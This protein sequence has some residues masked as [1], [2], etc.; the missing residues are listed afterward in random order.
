MKRRLAAIMILTIIV[1][2]FSGC[3]PTE[4]R[5]NE[6]TSGNAFNS[7]Y[8]NDTHFE[9]SKDNLAVGFDFPDVPN[10]LPSKIKLREKTFDH[11]EMIELFFGGEAPVSENIYGAN[12]ECGQ[13][14]AIDGAEL[15]IEGNDISYYSGKISVMNVVE[16]LKAPV[17][18]FSMMNLCK[19][20]NRDLYSIGSDELEDFSLQNALDSVQELISKLGLAGF[21]SP[22]IYSFSLAAYEKIR[23]GEYYM[24]NEEYPL[25]K[26]DEI[27][28]FVYPRLYG[29]VELS[30]FDGVDI[31]DS[32]NEIGT[33]ITS[34]SLTV[35]VAKDGIFKFSVGEAYEAD[36][37]ILSTEPVK[38]NFDYA[39]SVLE[40]YLDN[41]YFS[42]RKTV[43]INNARVLYFPVERN[44]AG[45]V[46]FTPLWSFEGYVRDMQ[47]ES[48]LD[49]VSL[50]DYRLIIN[51]DVG[52]V[53]EYE[54]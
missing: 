29:E 44:E 30:D 36:V 14:I 13:Y 19:E 27:Y 18:Y 6:N 37:G 25:E 40:K 7:D 34:S 47:I 35:G 51:S 49:H 45:T 38:Y 48:E 23:S 50:R 53:R 15:I 54:R 11:G 20:F 2:T 52:V 21:G 26:D 41:A 39:I 32:V 28:V 4:K 9:Y 1:L 24:F 5:V 33:L 17:D 46:E 31:K 8:L 12:D 3:Y 16:G 42:N 22:E 10:E 43:A